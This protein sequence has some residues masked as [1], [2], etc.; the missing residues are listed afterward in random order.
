MK[1]T[2]VTASATLD[3]IPRPNHSAKMGARMTRGMAL[4]A[5]RYGSSTAEA[6][7]ASAS[8]R[9]TPMPASVPMPKASSVS[10]S[11]THMWR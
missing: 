4:A 2:S 11:V 5:F 8:H 1:N 3:Q 6:K 10:I 9:P 7:G